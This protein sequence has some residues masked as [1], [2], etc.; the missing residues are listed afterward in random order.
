MKSYFVCRCYNFVGFNQIHC[1]RR[2]Q[3]DDVILA[4]IM[5]KRESMRFL[6]RFSGYKVAIVVEMGIKILNYLSTFSIKVFF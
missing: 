4:G 3:L 2:R 5:E 1:K 6:P